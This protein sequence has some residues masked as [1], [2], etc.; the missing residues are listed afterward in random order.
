MLVDF[1]KNFHFIEPLWLLGLVPAVLILW[2]LV[3][4][5]NKA[6]TAW[7][8]VINSKF[9]PYL[10]VKETA[11]KQTG[12]PILILTVV[13]VVA[14]ISLS[15]PTWKR[16][17]QP[18]FQ[19]LEAQ[20]IVLDLSPAILASDIKPSRLEQAKYKI[21]DLL[22]QSQGKQTGLVVYSG[23]AFTV[24]PITDDIDTLQSQ[25][26]V[27]EPSLM[28]T[29]GNRPD[30]GLQQAGKLLQQ[31][32]YHNGHII[33]IAES[34]G[35][36][37]TIEIAE[38]LSNIGYQISILGMGTEMGA[39]IPGIRGPE[40]KAIVSKVDPVAMKKISHAGK[41]VYSHFSTNMDDIHQILKVSETS[42]DKLYQGNQKS[43]QAKLNQ[44]NLWVQNGPWLAVLLLP[45]ALFSF[46]QGW[47]LVLPFMLLTSLLKPQPV[48]AFGWD[49]LW[50]RQEQ[51]ASQAF[52]KE[53]YLNAASLASNS[54]M[55]GAASYRAGNY[56][57]AITSFSEKNDADSN[58]NLA[59]AL[60]Q[61]G[62]YKKAIDSYDDALKKQPKMKDAIENRK[63]VEEM[64][65]QQEQRKQKQKKQENEEENKDKKSEQGDQA[66]K[67]KEDSGQ[68]NNGQKNKTSQS[69]Q[70]GENQ[71]GSNEKN[72][73]TDS[74]QQSK[75]PHDA[76]KQKGNKMRDKDK[77]NPD[78]QMSNSQNADNN[79]EN[80]QK[81]NKYENNHLSNNNND[82]NN[83]LNADSEKQ[84]KEADQT[85]RNAIQ[86][87]EDKDK[88]SNQK[89]VASNFDNDN[90]SPEERQSVENW[91]RR[92]PDDPGGLLRRKF[93]YQ[94]Q[95]RRNSINN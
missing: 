6:Q 69:D 64:L 9:M 63:L 94:Y 33:L 18:V 7:K 10:L 8:K 53:D 21:K 65:K 11:G 38:K 56:Q 60:A 44:A 48:M 59:N 39:P 20:V 71:K 13:W 92:V 34:A 22:R 67:N 31:A 29:R 81:K 61:T 47:F 72:Q 80:Q 41:G 32:G 77:S 83:F 37:N 73:S 25:L 57:Q 27:L 54:S 28:P 45:L 74:D 62:E 50:Q 51:R 49:D 4:H 89:T 87:N 23:E 30:L 16:L 36:R 19:Q 15:N 55:Q 58:Y 86:E 76:D 70:Q 24:T 91:L 79:Q 40:G 88:K 46:R 1:I 84:Q 14:I 82:D 66:S 35:N 85:V 95:Q 2:Q 68:E 75:N 43:D 17:P 90:L 42:D 12:L 93:L 5:R 26:R 78:E 52:K 3:R